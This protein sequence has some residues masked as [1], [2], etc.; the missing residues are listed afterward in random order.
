MPVTTCLRQGQTA[1]HALATEM[2]VELR[3][4]VELIRQIEHVDLDVMVLPD[5]DDP[6]LPMLWIKGG[7]TTPSASD[8]D[9]PL[10]IATRY[11]KAV[12]RLLDF[13]DKHGLLLRVDHLNDSAYLRISM[14][15]YDR[16]I[17]VLHRPTHPHTPV[18]LNILRHPWPKDKERLKYRY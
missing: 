15:S 4:D 11:G 6:R 17:V 1:C 9:V 5:R 3:R 8:F 7:R 10:S 12:C 13:V 16:S 14:R 18:H 2:D